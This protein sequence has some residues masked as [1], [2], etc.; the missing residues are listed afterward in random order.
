MVATQQM[1]PQAAQDA[2]AAV[3]G[4]PPKLARAREQNCK[5]CEEL[6]QKGG[7][8]NSTLESSELSSSPPPRRVRMQ[9]DRL[10]VGASER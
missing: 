2:V 1:A 9:S 10:K 5:F 3:A 8:N 4:G 7:E 6:R